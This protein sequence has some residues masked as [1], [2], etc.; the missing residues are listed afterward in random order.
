[1]AG[2]GVFQLHSHDISNGKVYRMLHSK[3][4][5]LISENRLEQ[6]TRSGRGAADCPATTSSRH[7][8]PTRGEEPFRVRS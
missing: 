1:M 5:V 2:P 7:L 3:H 4:D 6:G 8:A